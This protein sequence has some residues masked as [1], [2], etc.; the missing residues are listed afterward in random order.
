LE[1]F[2]P[3][4]PPTTRP[5]TPR[6]CGFF[7]YL[8]FFGPV[9]RPPGALLPNGPFSTLLRLPHSFSPGRVLSFFCR[10]PF[11]G[12]HFLLGEVPVNRNVSPRTPFD[13]HP[14]YLFT[15]G[16]TLPLLSLDRMYSVCR[17][18]PALSCCPLDPVLGW[19]LAPRFFF[20]CSGFVILKKSLLN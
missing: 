2:F 16:S 10:C 8:F 17:V 19:H 3:A 15:D 14:F 11:L 1:R 13:R 6:R 9:L 5:F 20:L 4:G 7:F 18:N 12:H